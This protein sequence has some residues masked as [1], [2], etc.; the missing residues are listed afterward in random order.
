MASGSRRR[1]RVIIYVVLILILALVLVWALLFGPKMMPGLTI[2]NKPSATPAGAVET[3]NIVVPKQAISQGTTLTDDL[4]TTIPYPKQYVQGSFFTDVQKVV[5]KKA[6]SALAAQ[7][8]ITQDNVVDNSGG[9]PAAYQIPKGM[10]AVSIPISRLSDVSYAPQSGDHVNVIVTLLMTDLDTNFQTQL[11]NLTAGVITPGPEVIS[12]S[13]G[14][15]SKPTAS[16]V[17]VVTV[18]QNLMA[19]VASGGPASTQGRAESDSSLG[20]PIYVV[21][22]ESQRPRMVSQ[23]LLQDVIVLQVGNFSLESTQQVAALPTATPV[24]NPAVPSGQQQVAAAAPQQPDVIT[25][26]VTPQDAITLNFLIYNNAKL[27]LALRSAGDDERVKTEAVTLQYLMD[28]YSIPVPAKLPYGLEPRVNQLQDPA[29]P[30]DQPTAV[31]R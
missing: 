4:L 21:P 15:A 28:Q 27:T 3:V 30:N 20:Q 9:S 17:G 29:L 25:L 22:S 11:P 10:V 23:S 14:D 12:S 16:S 18:H 13:G 24:A 2:G 8:P 1:G 31:P 7:L 5:G 6:K 19:E 26:V